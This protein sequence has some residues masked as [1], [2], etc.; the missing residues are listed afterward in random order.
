MKMNQ[1]LL[2]CG[3]VRPKTRLGIIAES[4]RVAFHTDSRKRMD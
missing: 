1:D 4:R 3:K 2:S